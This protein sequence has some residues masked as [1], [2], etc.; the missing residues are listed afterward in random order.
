MGSTATVINSKTASAVITPAPPAHL[1]DTAK[2]QWTANYIAA[3]AQARIDHPDNPG[4]QRTVALRSANT[5]LKV[6]EPRS[7]ADIE[8]L[9]PWQVLL[10]ST[11]DIDGVKTLLCVTADGRKYSFPIKAPV[12]LQ[13]MNKAQL[14]DHALEVHGLELDSNLKK[15]E[16]VAAI[17]KKA[18]K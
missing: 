11:R 13:A 16:M 5:I 9:E 14:V 3:H 1:S 4:A 8:A 7:A 15:D 18:A 12:D 17:E 2:K 10:R 6:P